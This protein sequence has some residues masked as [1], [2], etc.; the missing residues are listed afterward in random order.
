LPELSGTHLR[1]AAVVAAVIYLIGVTFF[2]LRQGTWP[3]PDFLIPPLILIAIL[4]GRG[5]SFVIDWLPFLMLILIYESFRG[6]A[7]DLNGRVHVQELIDAERW[8]TGRVPTISMQ[9]RFYSPDRVA[10]WDWLAAILHVAHFGMPVACGFVI[11]LMSRRLYWRYAIATVGLF[12]AGFVAVWAYPAAPPWLAAEWGFLPHVDRVL[13]S[14]LAQISTGTGLSLTYQDFSPNAVAAFPS[15]HAATPALL[16]LIVISLCG[17]RALPILL[18][19]L[20]GGVAWVY[21]GE[22]YVVDVLAGW[23]LAVAA[24]AGLWVMAPRILA[25]VES[26]S[27]LQNLRSRLTI[28]RPVPSWPL[29][30]TVI[31][32]AVYIWFNPLVNA[33]SFLHP[34]PAPQEEL[35]QAGPTLN[36]LGLVDCNEGTSS[37]SVPDDAILS[38]TGQYAGFIQ[39]LASGVCYIFTSV[40]AYEPLSE[41]EIR[42]LQRTGSAGTTESFL[43]RRL[44]ARTYVSMGAPSDGLLQFGNVLGEDVYA[45]VVRVNT[46][47]NEEAMQEILKQVVGLV[48]KFDN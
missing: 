5:W 40:R 14:T 7:D 1:S 9:E 20:L 34:A 35:A 39:G 42:Y 27:V 24:Y 46:E 8:L 37:T 32:A 6:I 13:G 23:L 26:L 11:W 22:H 43:N 44:Q 10:V 15:L 2:L 3:T 47:E 12:F 17:R 29:A 41:R 31:A 25:S 33:P 36:D 21:M 38:F 16:A 28:T 19:P 48:L 45:V 30:L 18:Y 4:I